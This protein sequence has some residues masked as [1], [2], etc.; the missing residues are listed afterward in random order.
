MTKCKFGGIHCEGTAT[1]KNNHGVDMCKPCH[2]RWV[3]LDNNT[4][5][6]TT[7]QQTIGVWGRK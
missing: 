1:M 4:R 5:L 2:S 3:V 6:P 7:C